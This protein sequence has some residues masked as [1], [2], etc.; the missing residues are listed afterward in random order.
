ML[1]KT[2]SGLSLELA[3]STNFKNLFYCKNKNKINSNQLFQI[4]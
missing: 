2:K 3:H 1:K 4:N